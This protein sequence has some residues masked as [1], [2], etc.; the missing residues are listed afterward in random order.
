MGGTLICVSGVTLADCGDV[1]ARPIGQLVLK[2]KTQALP[3]F[4]PLPPELPAGYAPLADYRAAYEA[5]AAQLIAFDDLA[6]SS[7]AKEPM[8]KAA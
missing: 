7:G 8:A 4:E 2:G 6:R 5:L 1:P 3:V